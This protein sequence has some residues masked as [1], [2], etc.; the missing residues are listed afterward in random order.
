MRSSAGR[1]RCT[2]WAG[3]PTPGGARRTTD[4]ALPWDLDDRLTHAWLDRHGAQVSTIDLIADGL[5]LYAEAAGVGWERAVQATGWSAPL[6]VE[7]VDARRTARRAVRSRPDGPSA[8]RSCVSR[9]G[10][11][12]VPQRLVEAV[13]RF[14]VAHVAHPGEGDQRRVRQRGVQVVGDRA[15][16][17]TSRSP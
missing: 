7:V 9:M 15:G 4:E 5:T 14:E 16:A 2:T 8:A 12:P 6:Q 3:P 1:S 10:P 11:E 17:R 13:G